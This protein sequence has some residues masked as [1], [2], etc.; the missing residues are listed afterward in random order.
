MKYEFILNFVES[1]FKFILKMLGGQKEE[2]DELF[3]L[4]DRETP[5]GKSFIAACCKSVFLSY[6]PITFA[7]GLLLYIT[8]G[9]LGFESLG[10]YLYWFLIIYPL[11]M[12]L[13]SYAKE[14]A[15][16]NIS[17]AK[18]T[19]TKYVHDMVNIDL[20]ISLAFTILI[21][22]VISLFR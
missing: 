8:L 11:V 7:L 18:T 14:C 12:A 15:A 19:G 1:N 22:L 6:S 13:L 20:L 2:V 3:I 17:A 21:L 9:L 5:Q 4:H 16:S 10:F